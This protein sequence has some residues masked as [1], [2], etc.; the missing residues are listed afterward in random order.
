M[1]P[2]PSFTTP[3]EAIQFIRD[4]LAQATPKQLYAA[5]VEQPSD[6]WRERLFEHLRQIETEATLEKVFLQDGQI[7]SF[8]E[9]ET[10]L[11][12]GG[13]GPF[14]HYL[15]IKLVQ[16]GEGWVLESIHMCR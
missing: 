5:F 14:T 3:L 16:V 15:D 12:L 11:Y 10:S 9:D 6:F 1:N 13:H 8:P 2:Q 4:C 7:S